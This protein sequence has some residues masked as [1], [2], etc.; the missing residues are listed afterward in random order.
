M[1]PEQIKICDEV[2]AIL[3]KCSITVPVPQ[4]T[5]YVK[6]LQNFVIMIN[7]EKELS[8]KHGKPAIRNKK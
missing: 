3:Q 7:A 1:K 2:V 8:S 5:V 4:M 6:A